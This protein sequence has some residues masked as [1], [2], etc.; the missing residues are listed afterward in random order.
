MDLFLL[1]VRLCVSLPVFQQKFYGSVSHC[2]DLDPAQ[3][4]KGIETFCRAFADNLFF[5][6]KFKGTAQFC[7]GQP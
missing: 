2:P 4:R 6:Q 5:I 7:L 1:L 3:H